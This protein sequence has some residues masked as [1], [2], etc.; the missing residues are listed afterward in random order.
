MLFC[1]AKIDGGPEG[2]KQVCIEEVI[3]GLEMERI[4]V[5]IAS[6]RKNFEV[7]YLK[8]KM[9]INSLTPLRAMI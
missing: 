6:S 1:R 7:D 4:Q 5:T 2:A 3:I 9:S 8:K